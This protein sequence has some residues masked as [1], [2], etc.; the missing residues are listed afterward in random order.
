[1]T[2]TNMETTPDVDTSTPP[3]DVDADVAPQGDA[4]KN[5]LHAEAAKYRV[6]AR[7]AEQARDALAQRVEALQTRELDHYAGRHLSDPKDITLSGKT[8]ADLL[9]EDG[10]VDPEAVRVAAAEVVATRPGLGKYSS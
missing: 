1:M 8:L 4:A 5:P 6:R 10:Y 3:A 9:D 7:E 2:E